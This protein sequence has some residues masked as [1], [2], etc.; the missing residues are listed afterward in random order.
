MQALPLFHSQ[1]RK[2]VWE[3]KQFLCWEQN[4]VEEIV[5]QLGKHLRHVYI[6]I[7]QM[8]HVQPHCCTRRA[9]LLNQP[10]SHTELKHEGTKKLTF[11]QALNK[12]SQQARQFP[13]KKVLSSQAVKSRDKNF[14][15][16]L[17]DLSP[18]FLVLWFL[19]LNTRLLSTIG[20]WYW[21]NYTA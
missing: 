21:F 17:S 9:T 16:N 2:Q 10:V 7:L 15:L 20:A 11:S 3:E 4:K 1:T 13:W 18:P 12:K 19:T 8:V 6:C 5:I 14:T